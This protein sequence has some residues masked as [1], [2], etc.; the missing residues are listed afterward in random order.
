A[1][2]IYQYVEKLPHYL[3]AFF[4]I[5]YT[6]KPIDCLRLSL[7]KPGYFL[8]IFTAPHIFLYIGNPIRLQVN[9]NTTPE[10]EYIYRQSRWDL[11]D[12]SSAAPGFQLQNDFRK[13]PYYVSLLFQKFVPIAKHSLSV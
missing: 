8:P 10:C 4:Q 2:T 7:T 6:F 1:P 11:P 13:S 12:M 5:S 3:L 9:N